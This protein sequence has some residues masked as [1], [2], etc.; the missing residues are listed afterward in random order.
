MTNRPSKRRR[1]IRAQ[2]RQLRQII[3]SQT[4]YSVH[5][6]PISVQT[7]PL[8]RLDRHSSRPDIVRLGIPIHAG[9]PWTR[10]PSS[11]QTS[12]FRADSLRQ[13]RSTRDV[14]A[15][16]GQ[17]QTSDIQTQTRH[18]STDRIA[19]DQTG[20]LRSDIQ[21]HTAQARCQTRHS[22]SA[23]EASD[24]PSSDLT[25]SDQTFQRRS[26]SMKSCNQA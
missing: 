21:A 16:T 11:N 20:Q 2:S 13:H 18:A 22:S 7:F 15:Q 6:R 3:Q 1:D 24:Q 5:E 25:V 8:L 26:E 9:Q 19:S 17:P 4:G 23:W 12:Q 14:Q 10:H